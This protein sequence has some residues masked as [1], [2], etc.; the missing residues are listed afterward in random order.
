LEDTQGITL[1]A[2]R[3]E[4]SKAFASEAALI[5][6]AMGEAALRL[7][8]V[9]S[10]AVPG[11]VAK[12]VIDI[13]ISVRRLQPLE[14]HSDALAK[15]GYSH[16]WLPPPDDVSIEPANDVYPFFQKPSTWPSTHH[17]HLCV[18]GSRQ[19][20]DHIVF[21]DYLRDHPGTAAAYVELKRRLAAEH[22]GDTLESRE[23]YSL[24]KSAFVAA[25][26]RAALSAG[27][28]P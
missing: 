4:W 13:Q 19:E 23:R 28:A 1:V 24:G 26:I 11:L 5:R 9:G 22:V 8:H 18:E 21:R 20:R 2:H 6:R 14:S 15:A 10:T 17:V 25:A 7:E 12:P 3:K 27:Y 16:V